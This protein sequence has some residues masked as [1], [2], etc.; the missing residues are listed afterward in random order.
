M[1][2][3]RLVVTVVVAGLPAAAAGTSGALL[4]ARSGP[5]RPV[6]ATVTRT[7]TKQDPATSARKSK[8]RR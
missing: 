5:D 7:D 1:S 4:V 6:P 8:S 2:Q 3:P